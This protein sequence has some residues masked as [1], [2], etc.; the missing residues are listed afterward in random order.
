MSDAIAEGRAAIAGV[1]DPLERLRRIAHLHLDRMSRDRD[2]A[3]VFQVELRQTTKFMERFSTTLLRDYLGILRDVIADGQ[4]A[5]VVRPGVNPTIAAKMLFGALD[6]MATNWMLSHRRYLARRRRRRDRGRVRRRRRRA[7]APAARR[8]EARLPERRAAMIRTA[9]VLGAGTMGAQIAAHL[10]NAGVEVHLLDVDAD[11]AAR[12]HGSARSRSSPIRSSP[13]RMRR[14]SAPAPRRRDFARPSADWIVEAI[15]ERLDPKRALFER[16]DRQ[17]GARHDRQL[18]HLGAAAR[19]PRRGPLRGVR[20]PLRRHALLQ[21]AALPAARRG[22][23]DG[24]HERDV[25]AALRHWLDLRLGQGVVVAKDSPNFIANH[26]GLYGC[27]R[28][29][30]P[31]S[32]GRFDIDSGRRDDRARRSAGR[33]AR[34]SAPS[35]S[36]A[37]TW[38]A[39]V[40]RN[41]VERT[42]V[43][44]SCSGCSRVPP[45]AIAGLLER[46]WIGEKA[47][48]GFFKRAKARGGELGHPRARSGDVRVR[49]AQQPARFASLDARASSEGVGGRI[50]ALLLGDDRVGDFPRA[51]SGDTL[52]YTARRRGRHRARHRRCRSRDAVGLRLGARPVRDHRRHRA[53][54]S[55]W[56]PCTPARPC[57]RCS[58]SALGRRRATR[59]RD[60]RRVPRRA[61]RQSLIL[62][63][64][65]R[66][67]RRRRHATPAASVLDP[68]T[69]S[70]PSSS[71]RR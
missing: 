25:V 23:P 12:R 49:A 60:A 2:L 11:A 22:H 9:T 69:A 33:R 5:G 46:G 37:S 6:E 32:E 27:S 68:A 66:P 14:C 56:T 39:Q 52:L 31:G 51:R 28:C 34:R 53:S 24:R 36:P 8:P 16:I 50:K 26:I 30:R 63:G 65:T 64:A 17:R 18:Q 44:P 40:A 13:R 3:V 62:A 70:S 45:L 48:Q 4:A 19:Q 29:C 54:R 61:R 43:E 41:F 7:H 55:C 21:S 58:P 20:R 67:A 59:F 47:G 10:A 71:T 38:L 35:T 15:V 1:S 42:S 57:R